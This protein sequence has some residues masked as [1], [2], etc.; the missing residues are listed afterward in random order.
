MVGPTDSFLSLSS[1]SSNPMLRYFI[2]RILVAVPTLLGITLVVFVL[3]K[4]IPGDPVAILVGERASPAVIAAQRK[5]LGLDRP[6]AVQYLI[7]LKNALPLKAPALAEV[8]LAGRRVRFPSIFKRPDLG[9]SYFTREP[10]SRILSEK[11]PNTVRLALAAVVLACLFGI[12]AGA[13]CARKAGTRLDRALTLLAAAGV[14]LPVFWT[15]LMLILVFS[16]LLGWLPASGMG[17]GA[18]VF[19]ILPAFTLASR[20]AAYLARVTR[21]SLLEVAGENFVLVARAK[22][23][24]EWLISG[25]H[26]FRNALIPLITLAGLDF[27][28]YLNGSVL[29]ETIFGWDGVGRLAM[30]AILRRDYPVILGCVLLGALVFVAANVLTDLLYALIDPRVRYE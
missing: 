14:S 28:S 18:A 5:S 17:G 26:I 25:K 12:A 22:G 9:F 29:T 4:S 16:G 6:L 24:P 10:V 27:A 13:V 1:A 2:K 7:F 30:T 19:L 20:S 21:S 11:F 8:A 3:M 23:L 15:G